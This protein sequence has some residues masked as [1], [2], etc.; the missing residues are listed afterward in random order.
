M[1]E[2]VRRGQSEGVGGG[3]PVAG[4][5]GGFGAVSE[6][7]VQRVVFGRFLG[8][9]DLSHEACRE[10]VASTDSVVAVAG[11]SGD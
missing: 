9:D 10:W 7:R 4:V 1:S 6:E 2:A 8:V 3:E 11:S 5:A